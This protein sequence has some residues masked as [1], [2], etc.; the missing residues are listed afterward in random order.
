[1]TAF[2]SQT[3]RRSTIAGSWYP[4]TEK[5]LE[6][7]IDEYLAQVD[8]PLVEG[9]LL[10]LISPHAGYPYSG[11][12]AAYAYYQLQ[13][14]E[15]DTVVIMGPSHRAW[16]GDFAASAEDAYET[17]LGRI[18][19]D[20]EF[21]ADLEGQ[22][23]LQRVRRDA[24]H[25]LEIQLPFLQHQLGDFR[26][27]PIMLSAN[28]PAAAQRL[29]SALTETIQQRVNEGERT[30]LVASSDMHHIE[31]YDEVVHRDKPVVEAIA[32]YD[33]E[34]LTPL[35]MAPGCSVCG[36]MPILAALYAAQDLGADTAKILHHTNS[37]DVTG[38]RGRGQY[39]VGYMA[40][41]VYRSQSAS[42]P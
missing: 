42:E 28:E 17:P 32:A 37:G 10:A 8:Q 16:V 13:G 24:E 21:I 2:K 27:V 3:V 33:L 11:Q 30:L 34:A 7:T 39:T 38:Q 23:P 4:G 29:A 35:L 6:R 36:R 1:M 18:P 12:T 26:L 9:E 25:S 22:I 31:N 20:R 41:A 15:V 5:A 14:R 19:L 40:A